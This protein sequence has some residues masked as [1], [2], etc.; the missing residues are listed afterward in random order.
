[1]GAALLDGVALGALG[2]EDLGPLLFVAAILAHGCL[3][4]CLL[5]S[6]VDT[7]E[8]A[9]ATANLQLHE[10]QRIQKVCGGAEKAHNLKKEKTPGIYL[11]LKEVRLVFAFL[12]AASARAIVPR[13]IVSRLPWCHRLPLHIRYDVSQSAS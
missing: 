3:F 7:M 8:N 11:Q 9:L 13:A 12:P 5:L 6:V 2:L 4:V 1:M 10:P